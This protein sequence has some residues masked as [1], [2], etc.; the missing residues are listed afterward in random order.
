[1]RSVSDSC[2]EI[3]SEGVAIKTTLKV[4][5]GSAHHIVNYCTTYPGTWSSQTQDKMVQPL[6][7]TSSLSFRSRRSVVHGCFS[8]AAQVGPALSPA[9]PWRRQ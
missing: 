8:A 6:L 1:M 2:T 9:L 7:H 4:D 5:C 3:I